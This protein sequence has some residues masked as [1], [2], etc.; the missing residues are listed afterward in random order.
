MALLT[1]TATATD[2]AGSTATGSVTVT[3]TQITGGDDGASTRDS[4][5]DN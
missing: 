3:V 4:R 5:G 2:S 1:I